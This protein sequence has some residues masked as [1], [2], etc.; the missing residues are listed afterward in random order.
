M[1]YDLFGPPSQRIPHHS[2]QH[3][4]VHGRR[5]DARMDQGPTMDNRIVSS[6]PHIPTFIRPADTDRRGSVALARVGEQERERRLSVLQRKVASLVKAMEPNHCPLCGSRLG[7]AHFRSLELDLDPSPMPPAVLSSLVHPMLPA[8]APGKQEREREREREESEASEGMVLE[9]S[10]EGEAPRD[11]LSDAIADA[12]NNG[13]F[14]RFFTTL[15][16]LGGGTFGEVYRVRHMLSASIPLGFYAVK[17]VAVGDSLLWLL[18]TLREV[19]FLESIHH[20]NIVGYHH[21]WLEI[22]QV[23]RMAPPVPHLFILLD[24]CPGGDLTEL[25]P[26]PGGSHAPLSPEEVLGL[27]AQ[28]FAGIAH[29]HQLHIVHRDIKPGNFLLT[30]DVEEECHLRSS[31]VSNPYSDSAVAGDPDTIPPLSVEKEAYHRETPVTDMRVVLTDFGQVADVSSLPPCQHTGMTGT[32]EYLAPEIV[33]GTASAATPEADVYGVGVCL[34]ELVCGETPPT[35]SETSPLSHL[36]HCEA[37]SD[38]GRG[39][40]VPV[41]CAYSDDSPSTPEGELWEMVNHII[42]SCMDTDPE[43]R[44]TP[45][46]VLDYLESRGVETSRQTHARGAR[47]HVNGD[48]DRWG[49]R[50][51]GVTIGTQTD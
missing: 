13:Y 14:D 17:R 9:M 38:A 36:L 7:Q 41:G 31:V 27:M 49:G 40:A 10:S 47:W 42:L 51:C 32:L 2:G 22:A 25:M 26:A 35:D 6:L 48:R 19:R 46:E 44:P 29:L 34:Y 30:R 16:R 28:M 5:G 15:E 39:G 4:G 50:P 45:C 24:L 37:E 23:C 11:S 21:A 8:L 3:R 43:R 12:L 1:E 18:R 33:S 20:P